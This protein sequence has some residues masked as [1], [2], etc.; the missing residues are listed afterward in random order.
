METIVNETHGAGWLAPAAYLSMAGIGASLAALLALHV[1]SSEFAP[2][3]RMV[4]EYANGRH[5]WLLTLVFI[6]WAVSSFA[7]VV[8]AWPLRETTQGKVSLV[9]LLLGGVGQAMGAF[10]DINHTLHGPAAMLGVPSLCIGAVLM[11][12]ALARRP[13]IAAPPVWSAHLPWIAFALMIG[14]FM[15]FFSSLQAAGVDVSGHAGPL[16]QLPTGVSAHI[17]WANR[18][19]FAVSYLWAVLA[20]VAV[21]RAATPRAKSSGEKK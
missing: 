15:L 16:K 12:R 1:A 4:S 21:V 20:S 13:D 5:E 3:W 8:A 2:S 19:L 7:L 9:F 6:G 18:A 14:A 11:T 10:F 17:G